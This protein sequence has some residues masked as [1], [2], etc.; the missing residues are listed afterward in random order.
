[1]AK[2]SLEIEDIKALASDSRLEILKTLDG[3]KLNLKDLSKS[4]SLK[5]ATLHVHL[6]KLLEAGFI[7]KRERQGHKWVYYQLTWKGECLLHP[8]NTQIVVLFSIAFV[9][10]FLGII[11]L[12]NYARGSIV[13]FA[14]TQPNAEAT[15]IFA[16]PKGVDSTLFYQQPFQNIAEV[17]TQNQTLIQLSQTMNSK[18]NVQGLLGN[19]FS[20]SA[21]QWSASPD[22]TT[23]IASVQDPTL[24]NLGIVFLI[25]F[26]IFLCVSIWRLWE[27]KATE[28]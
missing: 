14:Q 10:L 11:Q 20:D 3:K 21:I 13:G 2:I 18:A 12:I 23:L 6:S 9:S 26:V 24:F 15:Q 25:V 17:P 8:E 5:K 19:T 7:K 16:I 28:L 22:S 27:S 1:M 4:T